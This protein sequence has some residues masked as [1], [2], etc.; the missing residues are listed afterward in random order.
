MDPHISAALCCGLPLPKRFHKSA[1]AFT[2]EQNFERRLQSPGKACCPSGPPKRG[3]VGATA[4]ADPVLALFAPPRE[5][6][7]PEP[8]EV[9]ERTPAP[10]L[11]QKASAASALDEPAKPGEIWIDEDL[12]D[13]QPAGRLQHPA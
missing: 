9:A 7:R 4:E 13:D 12:A 10:A 5:L 1:A 8:G 6:R 3:P 2:R 11:E